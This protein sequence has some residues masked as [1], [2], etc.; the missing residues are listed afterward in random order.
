MEIGIQLTVPGCDLQRFLFEDTVVAGQKIED[1]GLGDHEAAIDPAHIG[2]LFFAEM[3]NFPILA[4]VEA[5]KTAGGLHAGQGDHASLFLMVV[6]YC[7]HIDIGD[8]VAIG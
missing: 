4:D 6:I 3:C 8:S 5:A 7:P 2:L 1:S